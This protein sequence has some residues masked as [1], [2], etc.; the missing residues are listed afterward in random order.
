MNF[1]GSNLR[2]STLAHAKGVVMY[3][4]NQGIYLTHSIPLFPNFTADGLINT[5]VDYSE[6]IYAQNIMC[7]SL[8]SQQLFNLV[9]VMAIIQPIM[10]YKHLVL[11][12]DNVTKFTGDI[13]PDLPPSFG[14]GFIQNDQQFYYI[15]KSR[16]SNLYLWDNSV[17]EFFQTGLRVESWGRPYMP[18]AC[19][20]NVPYSVL[21]IASLK[22]LQYSWLDT[23][24]HSKWA[25]I[26]G[27]NTVCYGD[28][29]RMTSQL[30]RGGGTLCIKLD[31]F[32]NIHQTIITSSNPCNTASASLA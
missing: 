7:V 5:T 25:I 30:G 19:P 13:L 18:S 17:S 14:F 12:N 11:S 20:P 27:A 10:Y 1:T 23:Q 6:T 15:A 29:N 2:G 21:N 26:D 4:S 8:T 3:N 9:G 28:M 22:V 16:Y 24:D 31:W 32:Y